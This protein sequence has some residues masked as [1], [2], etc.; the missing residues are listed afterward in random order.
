[1]GDHLEPA[2]DPE[3]AEQ[4]PPFWD[5]VTAADFERTKRGF[6]ARS[7][8][9]LANISKSPRRARGDVVDRGDRDQGECLM[10]A[11]EELAQRPEAGSSQDSRAGEAAIEEP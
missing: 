11:R 6:I 5:R 1:M 2:V 3:D 4:L 8:D 10:R 7:C 9:I